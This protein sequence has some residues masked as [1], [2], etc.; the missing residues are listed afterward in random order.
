MGRG[1]KTFE[2]HDRKSL[3]CLSE[4]VARNMDI[5]GDAA[6]CSD[7]N[8]KGYWELEESGLALKW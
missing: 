6:K 5:K 4:T 1:W 8:G 2:M 3:D 7:E